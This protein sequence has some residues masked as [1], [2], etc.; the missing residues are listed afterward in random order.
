MHLVDNYYMAAAFARSLPAFCKSRNLDIAPAAERTGVDI[1]K[2]KSNHAGISL[3]R[4]ANLLELLALQADDDCFGLNFGQAFKMGDSGPFGFCLMNAP[5]LEAIVLNYQRFIPLTAD[6]HSF[7]VNYGPVA[8]EIFWNYAPIIPK[9]DQYTDMMAT[10]THRVLRLAAGASWQPTRLELTRATPKSATLH[11]HVL[12][13]YTLF[14]S[15]TNRIVFPNSQLLLPNPKSDSRMFAIMKEQCDVLLEKRNAKGTML[16]ELKKEILKRLKNG[17]C[18][19][20]DIALALSIGER[21]LQRR[22][23]QKNTSFEMLVEET[24][25]ELAKALLEMTE[26]PLADVA[27][28]VGYSGLPAFSRASKAWFGMAPSQLRRTAGIGKAGHDHISQPPL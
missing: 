13:E 22:L 19:I 25:K 18:K 20:G 23:S 27:E 2:F 6:Y 5:N 12:C 8:V 1:L 10:L 24:R 11:R 17:E 28:K 9:I 21:S 15:Q 3:T 26:L 7:G 4:F 16:T 14:G